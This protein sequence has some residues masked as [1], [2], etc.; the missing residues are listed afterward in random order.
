M[1]AWD[2]SRLTAKAAVP[3]SSKEAAR[4]VKTPLG[5]NLRENA[6]QGQYGDAHGALI[7]EWRLSLVRHRRVQADCSVLEMKFL[8]SGEVIILPAA[9]FF[10]DA[11][12]HL[13]HNRSGPCQPERGGKNQA[14]P[15][16]FDCGQSRFDLGGFP[17]P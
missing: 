15:A 17:L 2:L 14:R 7:V 8:H 16:R 12:S 1:I 4:L 6:G 5:S 3:P 9:V 10:I 13:A 11:F